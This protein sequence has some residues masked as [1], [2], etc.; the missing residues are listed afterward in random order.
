MLVRRLSK[1]LFIED[2]DVRAELPWRPSDLGEFTRFILAAR[3]GGV[4]NGL[5]KSVAAGN[6][7]IGPRCVTPKSLQRACSTAVL[8]D[9]FG[10]TI[11]MRSLATSIC[12]GSDPK[13]RKPAMVMDWMRTAC[14][15]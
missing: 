3:P 4:E 12:C 1:P 10:P 9:A 8:P 15:H 7:R 2:L 5:V 13:Q 6:D 14:S 11:A